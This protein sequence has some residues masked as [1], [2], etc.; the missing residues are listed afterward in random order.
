[1]EQIKISHEKLNEI[2]FCIFKAEY[3]IIYDESFW[4]SAG[5]RRIDKFKSGGVYFEVLDKNKLLHAMM[6][7]DFTI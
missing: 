2:I 6:K 7:Y 1:L 3:A 5:L 4:N